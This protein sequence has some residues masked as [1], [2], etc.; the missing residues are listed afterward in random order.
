MS[1]VAD[2]ARRHVAGAQRLAGERLG[3]DGERV[4]REREEAPHRRGDLVGRERHV[5]EPGRD[6]GGD[7]QDRPQREG[8]HQQR[9]AG[10]CRA[11]HPAGVGVQGRHRPGGRAATRT[12]DERRSPYR[13]GAMTV[14]H[15]DPAMPQPNP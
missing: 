13:S 8:A 2:R 6:P 10:E 1:E 14:P 11:Q 7:Q 12:D 5:A 9:Y 15:A 3:G 4:E